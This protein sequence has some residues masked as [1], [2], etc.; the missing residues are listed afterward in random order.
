[1]TRIP[2][3]H[4]RRSRLNDCC[5]E[6]G[7]EDITPQYLKIEEGYPYDEDAVYCHKCDEAYFESDYWVFEVAPAVP[8]SDIGVG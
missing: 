6:C 8:V 2:N 5:P 7:G 4:W 3:Y 1:M